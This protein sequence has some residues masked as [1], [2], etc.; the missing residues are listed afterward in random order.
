MRHITNSQPK[1][2]AERTRYISNPQRKRLAVQR[3]Y[4]KQHSAVL[5][6]RRCQY[7]GTFKSKRAAKLLRLA[8]RN[9]SKRA[10]NKAIHQQ[11]KKRCVK[12]S[13]SVRHS[14]RE[15]SQVV[16]ERYIQNMKK[17]IA[18]NASLRQKLLRAFKTCRKPLADKLQPSKLTNAVANIAVR[19][20]LHR[21]LQKR[22]IAVRRLLSCAQSIKELEISSDDFGDGLLC[23]NK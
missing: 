14:L 8:A 2:L 18:S 21:V 3:L 6:K 11:L 23:S 17:N 12:K 10:R 19:R 9:S 22:R 13:R 7:Y 20:V 1:K 15:S 5:H 16:K 4:V